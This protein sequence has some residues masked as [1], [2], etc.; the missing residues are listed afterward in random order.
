M[1]FGID[2]SKTL[3]NRRILIVM[4]DEVL[5]AAL[6]FMLHDESEAHEIRSPEEAY[7][8]KFLGPV[9]LVLLD[10][11]LVWGRGIDLIPQMR[12]RLNPAK[13]VLVAESDDDPDAYACLPAGADGILGKPLTVAGVRK[14]VERVLAQDQARLAA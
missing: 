12:E 2:T 11:G 10:L 14:T 4:E 8:K 7:H 1:N 13:L 3:A 6:Q 5:R 9:D